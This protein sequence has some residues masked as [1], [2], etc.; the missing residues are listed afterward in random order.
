[1]RYA[2]VCRAGG[3]VP[4]VE[5]D[6]LMDG[7]HSLERCEAATKEALRI[8]FASLAAH[9]VALDAMVLK[10]SMEAVDSHR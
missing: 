8:V 7:A 5:P 2:R 6:V 3:L 9:G 10:P 1:M 4:I